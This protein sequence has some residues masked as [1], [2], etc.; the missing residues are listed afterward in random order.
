MFRSM[1]KRSRNAK[2]IATLGPGRSSET[3]IA[4]LVEAGADIFRLNFS[5]GT[6]ED[7]KKR[8]DIIRGLEA[9]VGRPIGVLMDLQGPKLRV[10]QFENGS[11]MLEAGQPFRLELT[12]NLGNETVAP[13][14][15][16]EIFAALRPE[17][18]LLLDDGTPAA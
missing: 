7:H 10:G 5:H 15:H 14:P 1:M 17:M 16:P 3:D 9:K 8:C 13:M 4:E 12:E 18:E 2:I 6:H 11:I